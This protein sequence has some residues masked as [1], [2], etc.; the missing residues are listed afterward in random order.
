MPTKR[1]LLFSMPRL[2]DSFTPFK[3]PLFERPL[4]EGQQLAGGYHNQLD[5]TMDVELSVEPFEV[6]VHRMFRDRKCVRDAVVALVFKDE[7][8]DGE[9]L[10]GKAKGL[11]NE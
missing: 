10:P 6:C 5:A 9:F 1:P 4:P 11:R 3:S 8:E 7:F 2:Y